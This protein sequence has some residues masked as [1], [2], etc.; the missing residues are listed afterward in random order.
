MTIIY[1][2]NKK[3]DLDLNLNKVELSKSIQM[4]FLKNEKIEQLNLIENLK[5]F[6]NKIEIEVRND[7][8]F[9]QEKLNNELKEFLGVKDLGL[10]N[11]NNNFYY[12]DDTNLKKFIYQNHPGAITIPD[13]KRIGSKNFLEYTMEDMNNIEHIDF[14]TIIDDTNELC[15]I[16]QTYL[17]ICNGLKSINLEKYD[18]ERMSELGLKMNINEKIN[19]FIGE[20]PLEKLPIKDNLF[21]SHKQLEKKQSYI[22]NEINNIN[23]N[24]DKLEKRKTEF[25]IELENINEILNQNDHL[26]N[27]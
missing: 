9:N 3:R 19:I 10:I 2:T 8:S 23:N 13:R 20:K 5:I 17:N 15:K 16:I 4:R 18:Y 12:V 14:Y 7:I 25:E 24:I 26:I 27:R 11:L 22:I 1:E 6:D 21:F